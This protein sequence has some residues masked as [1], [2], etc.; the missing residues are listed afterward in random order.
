MINNNQWKENESIRKGEIWS[1][2]KLRWYI[3]YIQREIHPTVSAEAELVL[4]KYYQH[5]RGSSLV[6]VERKT[7]RMLESLIR[8]SQAHARL[9]Y[10]SEILVQDA[11]FVILLMEHALM[12]NLLDS[13]YSC[14][15]SEV[16]YTEA[17]KEVLYKLE[18]DS[19][20][21]E[22]AGDDYENVEEVTQVEVKEKERIEE[23]YEKYKD[24]IV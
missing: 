1:V 4:Q 13:C 11:I 14:K 8:L 20:E 9:M 21:L 6:P 2:E 18:I 3:R 10:R 16:E 19:E 23:L 12:T 7:L 5:L 24:F 15:L 22:N 17:E